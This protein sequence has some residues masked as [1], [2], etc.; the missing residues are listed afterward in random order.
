MP[1]VTTKLA[2]AIALLIAA[3]TPPTASLA[4]DCA[5]PDTALGV[6]RVVEIDA[7]NGPLF[8]EISVHERE[9]PLLAPKEVILTFDDGPMPWI[10][11]SILDTLDTF[12]TKAT[13]FSVGRMALAY[14]KSVK[15][16]LARGHTL[17]SHT[18]S[19]PL[20]IARLSHDKAVDQI[21]RGIA[22]VALA[23]GQPIAPF[24]R[25]PGLSDSN[26]LLA[27]L[28]TR[29]IATF[30]VD[31]VSNDSFIHDAKRLTRLTL[32]EVNRLNGG[33]VLFHDIKSTTAKALPDILAG[34]KAGGYKVVHM[35]AKAPVQPLADFDQ[36][37]KPVLAKAA[38]EDAS[39]AVQHALPFF[40]DP[41]VLRSLSGDVVEVTEVSPAAKT[42][43]DAGPTTRSKRKR[44][45]DDVSTLLFAP[46]PK[47]A[48]KVAGWR[49]R[50]KRV[51]TTS[52][53]VPA[54]F[55]LHGID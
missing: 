18:W 17:G 4:S 20:N 28:Q 29:G 40:G 47:P 12:C 15:D 5:K 37:L 45:G 43:P 9:A 22:A 42:R 21:E 23:A 16:V 7:A 10:T 24:F 38:I 48:A 27:H 46:T 11:K 33:I 55:N 19:H 1:N 50:S 53:G 30:T 39:G 26:A 51:K 49:I 54:P 32:A 3:A 31:V 2:C 35:R 25:F 6:D 52:H 13:F 14:P 36:N 8:G 44:H 34:L 41:A